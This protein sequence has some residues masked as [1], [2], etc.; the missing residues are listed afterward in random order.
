MSRISDIHKRLIN[1]SITCVQLT[2]TCLQRIR[3]TKE[4]NSYI[5]VCEKE[6]L[7]AAKKADQR[8][9]EGLY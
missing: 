3:D 2:E 4:L 7:N 9:K 8:I 1:C 6:A 5:T